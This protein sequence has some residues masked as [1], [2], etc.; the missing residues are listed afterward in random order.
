MR[1]WLFPLWIII[2]VLIGVAALS[3]W[4]AAPEFVILNVCLTVFAIALAG[5]LMI[6]KIDEIKIFVKSKYFYKAIQLDC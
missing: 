3:L 1:T 5:I 6:A 2:D 4:I